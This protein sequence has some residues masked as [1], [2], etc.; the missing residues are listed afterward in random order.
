MW[1]GSLT[2]IQ[3]YLSKIMIVLAW[4]VWILHRNSYLPSSS[5]QKA[6]ERGVWFYSFNHLSEPLASVYGGKGNIKKIP[7][8]K[9]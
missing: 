7:V 1:V 3:K 4:D 9:A 5:S 6:M 8:M 2:T